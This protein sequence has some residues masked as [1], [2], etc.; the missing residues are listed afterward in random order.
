MP[1]LDAL[2]IENLYQKYGKPRTAPV[3]RLDNAPVRR[4]APCYAVVP[5]WFGVDCQ[6]VNLEDAV[7]QLCDFGEAFQPDRET[8]T[9]TNVP[10]LLRPPEAN[11][12]NQILSFSAD[13]WTLACTLYEVLGER[14]LFEGFICN[15]DDVLAENISTIGELPPEWDAAWKQRGDFFT[16]DGKWREDMQ[17]LHDPRSRPLAERVDCMGRGGDGGFSTEERSDVLD[18]L[19]KMLA[20][21][22]KER[23]TAEELARVA[24]MESWGLPALAKVRQS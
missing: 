3:K 2:S 22:P 16:S 23:I 5:V 24:W 18:M 8:R 15:A 7:V 9:V 10:T 12:D 13:I 1:T 14:S 21:K 17:R 20:F 6:D 4:E 11:F 19:S